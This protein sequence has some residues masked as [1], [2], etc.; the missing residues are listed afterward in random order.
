ML[1][2]GLLAEANRNKGHREPN[3]AFEASYADVQVSWPYLLR[4]SPVVCAR[5]G[6][7]RV[8]HVARLRD[9]GME[10]VIEK[11]RPTGVFGWAFNSFST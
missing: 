5:R 9:G 8:H 4:S 7:G 3:G 1:R 10:G 11:K 2:T 6:A